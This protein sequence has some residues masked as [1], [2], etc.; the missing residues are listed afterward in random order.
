[1]FFLTCIL[2]EIHGAYDDDELLSHAWSLEATHD[3]ADRDF[4]AASLF[5]NIQAPAWR[6]HTRVNCWRRAA[7]RV[8]CFLGSRLRKSQKRGARRAPNTAEKH[9]PI[10]RPCRGSQL[11]RKQIFFCC[12]GVQWHCRVCTGRHCCMLERM[13]VLYARAG[14]LLPFASHARAHCIL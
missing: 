13:C 2:R 8:A 10:I 3:V 9:R 7:R 6:D 4:A 11:E 1:M 5:A 14:I 12:A